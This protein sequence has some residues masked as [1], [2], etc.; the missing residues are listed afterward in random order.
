MNGIALTGPQYVLFVSDLV[1]EANR[2][3][4]NGNCFALPTDNFEAIIGGRFSAAVIGAE[5][6]FSTCSERPELLRIS[7]QEDITV[8]RAGHDAACACAMRV[9]D[10]QIMGFANW[11]D[12]HRDSLGRLCNSLDVHWGAIRARHTALAA[13]ISSTRERFA[14]SAIAVNVQRVA[15][16]GVSVRFPVQSRQ[17]TESFRLIAIE[18]TPVATISAFSDLVRAIGGGNAPDGTP[19]LR[20]AR[21]EPAVYRSVQHPAETR[22]VNIPEVRGQRQIPA[23][24]RDRLVAAVWGERRIPAVWGDRKVPQVTNVKVKICNVSNTNRQLLCL[25]PFK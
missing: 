13:E 8:L 15:I 19:H 1:E 24:Y 12:Q 5:Q 4:R 9:F 2:A 21:D 25:P 17:L 7:G 6:A 10:D 16:N 14:T 18:H 3:I 20:L 23:V 22:I 11:E